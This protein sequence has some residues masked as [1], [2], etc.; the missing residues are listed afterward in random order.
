MEYDLERVHVLYG[1]GVFL[2]IL[3]FLYFA[4]VLLEDLSP[5][6]TAVLLFLGFLFFGTA[7]LFTRLG[8]LETVYYALSAGAYLVGVGYTITRFD[9][10]DLAVFVLLAGSS[11]LF[12]ALGYLSHMGRVRIDRKQARWAMVVIV[13]LAAGILGADVL[14]PQ[15]GADL[16]LVDTVTVPARGE[17]VEIGTV[18]I[19]NE[20]VLSRLAERPRYHGCLYL[21]ERHR[22]PI[23]V[24][25]LGREVLLS[26]GEE[27]TFRLLVRFEN[28][29][30]TEGESTMSGLSPG[31]T[32]PVER[33]AT[34]P[35]G[36][37]ETKLVISPGGR[38]R[39]PV[40]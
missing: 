7:G 10:G 13:V 29:E 4:F 12:I 17:P 38:P 16:S 37:D 20:F 30:A 6:V 8:R 21:E 11:M 33:A 39:P 26:G 40:G 35:E 15:P 31:D 25:G 27:I 2:G 5:T 36:T 24:D 3:S 34:C 32:V 23:R 22:V 19:Q 28:F 1:V 14:G 18:R 9:L